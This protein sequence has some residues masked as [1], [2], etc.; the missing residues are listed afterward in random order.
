[1]DGEGLYRLHGSLMFSVVFLFPR[2]SW[3]LICRG[4]TLIW[5]GLDPQIPMVKGCLERLVPSSH[6]KP[7]QATSGSASFRGPTATF[8]ASSRPSQLPRARGWLKNV[9]ILLNRISLTKEPKEP[10]REI[11]RTRNRTRKNPRHTPRAQR[12]AELR[13]VAASR[14]SGVDPQR[15]LSR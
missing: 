15:G 4:R 10:A 12:A 9:G 1:M 6:K 14:E 7:P 5:R 8:S 11:L 2:R 3:T 13:C